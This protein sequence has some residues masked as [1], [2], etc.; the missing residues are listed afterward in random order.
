MTSSRY[1]IRESRTKSGRSEPGAA[2]PNSEPLRLLESSY[3]EY[4]T[5]SVFKRISQ[6]GEGTYGKVYKAVN[7]RTNN[8]V[9]LKR[10]RLETERDGV[11]ITAVREIKLLQLLRHKNIVS[12]QEMMVERSQIF[13]VFEYAD[14]DLAGVLAIPGLKMS[15]GNVKFIFRQVM[16]GLNY[17]HHCGVLHRDIKCSNILVSSKGHVL[18][19]DFGLARQVDLMNPDAIY[20]NRVITL[21]YRPPELLLGASKY[22]GAVDI[23]GMGCILLEL[24]TR[25]AIFQA[26]EEV[27]QLLAIYQTMGTPEHNDWLEARDLPW[28]ELLA[29]SRSLPP[30]FDRMFRDRVPEPALALAREMLALNPAHRITARDTLRHEFLTKGPPDEKPAQL[31]DLAGE[32]HDYEA[33][34]RR[35]KAREVAKQKEKERE[36][37]ESGGPS[38]GAGTGKH[39]L[40]AD[41]N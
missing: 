32:W 11:P 22:G 38:S 14:H 27:G 37:R 5:E 9:A 13:M 6:V 23:W 26:N 17:I 12:L 18:L 34:K 21:W 3:L 4:R 25:V 1:K 39:S 31:A 2:P 24:F 28:A 7:T 33:K 36:R 40:A 35:R 10:L 15:V 8:M 20:T 30:R 41:D 29:P 16:D 19:A